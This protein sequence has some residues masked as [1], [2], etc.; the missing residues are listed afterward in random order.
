[1]PYVTDLTVKDFSSK[2]IYGFRS[3]TKG[4]RKPNVANTCDRRFSLF[5]PFEFSITYNYKI[6][7]VKERVYDKKRNR[8]F[9][10]SVKKSV[11]YPFYVFEK[12]TRT[13]REWRLIYTAGIKTIAES[14]I[15]EGLLTEVMLRIGWLA[16]V[17][18]KE[19][20]CKPL[21]FKAADIQNEC[22]AY[23][24]EIH[25]DA[26]NILLNFD[27]TNY[28]KMTSTRTYLGYAGRYYTH[29]IEAGYN[30]GTTM[31]M[32]Y[33]RRLFLPFSATLT[34]P[35]GLDSPVAEWTRVS[36]EWKR[37]LYDQPMQT[38][39]DTLETIPTLTAM[40]WPDSGDFSDSNAKPLVD[41]AE[42]ISDGAFPLGPPPD[43]KDAHDRLMDNILSDKRVDALKST[44]DFASN[45]WLWNSLVLQPVLSSAVALSTSVKA[46]DLAID[47][48]TD[49]A[50]SNQW[51]KGKSL[52]FLHNVQ[53]CDG[54]FLEP[55]T[56]TRT[57]YG[58]V[59]GNVT[60]TVTS[61]ASIDVKKAEANAMMVYK[62]SQFD[63]AQMNTSG[64]RLSQFFN[65]IS[66][67]VDTIIHNVLP[68]SFVVDWFTSEYTGMLNLKD[69]VY[70]PVDQHKLIVS[71]NLEAYV[72]MSRVGT[73]SW[74]TFEST[75]CTDGFLYESGSF[76]DRN[77]DWV[78]NGRCNQIQG[79]QTKSNSSDATEYIKYYKRKV[80]SNPTRRTDFSSSD[81]I[82]CMDVVNDD[83]LNMGK[84]VTLGALLWGFSR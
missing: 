39:F 84:T 60:G 83:P 13:I 66:S 82:P 61:N 37:L 28:G 40:L 3:G 56:E 59:L 36:S 47:K 20:N 70:M 19:S 5:N 1:M 11:P 34:G 76:T 74:W 38:A 73:A 67:D 51:I 21:A 18:K 78:S 31:W 71:Y 7:K 55:Y 12:Q 50:K 42:A 24:T 22:V 6:V 65:R 33:G 16:A 80:Y 62:L 9:L 69:K 2:S 58:T 15:R 68:L 8:Y 72:S 75:R 14:N 53:A 43:A 52:R 27:Q 4:R 29:E 64:M 48:Y 25:G 41:I 46:N 32:N 81:N 17:L 49:L 23:T 35:S 10:R 30:P 77:V 79:V 45:A 63:A 54:G 26:D 44:I 57:K